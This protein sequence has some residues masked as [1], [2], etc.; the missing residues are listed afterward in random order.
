MIIRSV[1]SSSD[2][3]P[4][5]VVPAWKEV[6]RI[7]RETQAA[8][9]LVSQPDHAH[10]SGAI[11]AAFDTARL[12]II[13]DDIVEAIRVHD[14]GWAQFEGTAAEARKPAMKDDG[15]PVT[16]LD[17]APEMFLKAWAGSIKAAGSVSRS[18]EYVVSAHFRGLAEHRLATVVD[19]PET[20][21][22]LTDFAA[23][24]AER[25]REL[26]PKTGRASEELKSAVEAL[27][28]CDLI[29]LAVC[30]GVSAPVE[31]TNDFGLG[32][33]RMECVNGAYRLNPTPFATPVTLQFEVLRLNAA[34]PEKEVVAVTLS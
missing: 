21:E 10:L 1:G 5:P 8:Y 30:A 15:R 27:R 14:E 13:A 2:S 12:P 23:R 11:A 31:F 28:F 9:R 19:S 3:Q 34:Q 4:S 18:G 29:S 33:I 6:E 16:F 26:L 22:R 17:V 25:E 20:T 7:Q 24:E 32:T